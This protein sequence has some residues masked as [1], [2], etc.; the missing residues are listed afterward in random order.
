MNI[1]YVRN[2]SCECSACKDRD[3]F[4]LQERLNN[5]EYWMRGFIYKGNSSK[6]CSCHR[7]YRLTSRYNGIA[8]ASGLP[9]YEELHKLKYL[10]ETDVFKKLKSL[11]EQVAKKHL[12]NVLLFVTGGLRNQKT[13]SIAKTIHGIITSG[14][15][16]KYLLFSDLIESF[17]KNETSDDLV[18]TDWLIIDD[19][20]EGETV[21]FKTTYNQ[22]Y[23][24]ILKRNKP[25]I[26]VSSLS[27]DDL[28]NRKDLPSYNY[29]ML[30]KMFAKIDA[31]NA[32][33][34]FTENIDKQLLGKETIDLWSL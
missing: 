21:N 29:D 5:K 32:T 31:Y 26:I 3:T 4:T 9:S 27:K 18:S 2:P 23:N 24:L 22:F 34:E 14:K 25:T 6:E 7:T 28:M 15:T 16:V 8:E 13:T 1:E 33:L 11:P 17:I 10:G 19:C 30:V 20:F 12:K